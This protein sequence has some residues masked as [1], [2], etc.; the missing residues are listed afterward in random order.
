MVYLWWYQ[1]TQNRILTVK[2]FTVADKNVDAAKC[3]I[4]SSNDEEDF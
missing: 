3:Q 2:D 4:C 1:Q